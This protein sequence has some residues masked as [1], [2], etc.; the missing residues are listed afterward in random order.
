MRKIA[1]AVHH[2]HTHK[3]AHRDLKPENLLYANEGDEA[4]LKLID[5][6]FAKECVHGSQL[7]TPCYTPFYAAPE[8]LKVRMLQHII[9]LLRVSD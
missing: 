1:N 4:E 6:G 7:T 2:L 8:V 3:V 5:F 9:Y